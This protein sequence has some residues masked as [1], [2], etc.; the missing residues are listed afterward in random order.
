MDICHACFAVRS[1][2]P[3]DIAE[4]GFKRQI[5]KDSRVSKLA[6]LGVADLGV[7]ARQS[8]RLAGADIVQDHFANHAVDGDVGADAEGDRRDC[9]G[10]QG[11]GFTEPSRGVDDVAEHYWFNSGMSFAGGGAGT[12]ARYA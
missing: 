6:V 12:L 1:S 11:R 10:G 8:I 5:L 3:I 7:H 2:V 9:D 4:A